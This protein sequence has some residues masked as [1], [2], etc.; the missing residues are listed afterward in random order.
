MKITGL[1]AFT[2]AI[3]FIAPIFSAYGMSY[4]ARIRTFIRVHTDEGLVGI[5]EAGVSATH[6]VKRGEQ[7]RVFEETV[8]RQIIGENPFDYLAIMKKLRYIPESIAVE[9]A[10]WDLMGKALGLPV[11]RLLGGEGSYERVPMAAYFFFRGANR[12]GKLKVDLDNCAEHARWLIETY[13]FRTVKMKLGVY[14][15]MLEAEA[16]ERVRAAI[17]PHVKLRI[18]P[19]GCWSLPVAKR[20][21]KRLENCDLEYVEEPIKYAP[22]RRAITTQDGVPSVDTLGLA[23]LRRATATPIAADGVYRIDMVWQV[24]REQAADVILADIQG[25]WGIR[26]MHDFYTVAHVLNLAGGVHSGTEMGVLQAAKLHVTAAHPELT[27]AGDA[28]YHEYADD[29]LT[30]GM[31]PYRDGFM[32][33]PQNPGLGI[34]LDNAK[35]AQY[36]L[37]E[38]KHKEYDEYW[39]EVKR[40]YNIPPAGADLLVRHF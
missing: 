25:C 13:G 31:L 30:G 26:G 6:H 10:C 7:A 1:D 3:P 21:L 33:V 11:Y 8:K 20:V 24:A 22:A 23:A 18:D 38:S 27:I 39:S 9:V 5:G 4:P 35:L 19:N 16:V 15:P 32:P 37:T 36:E 2:V 40:Q 14:E 29:V 34:E 17:G 28:I 12:E